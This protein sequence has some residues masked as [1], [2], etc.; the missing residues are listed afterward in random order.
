VLNSQHVLRL[1]FGEL[2]EM[3]AVRP[4]PVEASTLRVLERLNFDQLFAYSEPKR[5]LRS[6]TVRGPSL[7]IESYRDNMYYYFNFKAFPS[8][9]HRRHKGYI[10]FF[11]PDDFDTP[12]EQV[13]CEVDCDCKDY[14]FRWAWAN[15]QRDSS[16]IG[17][18]SLNQCIDQAPRITNPTA[19][20]GLCKHLL[21][22]R[23]FLYGQDS[24]FPPSDEPE[25]P[26]SGQRGKL[27]AKSQEFYRL[28]AISQQADRAI[29]DDTGRQIG[30]IDDQGEPVIT[31]LATVEP[32]PTP[33]SALA[34]L[35]NQDLELR[36]RAQIRT[37][38]GDPDAP[39]AAGELPPTAPTVPHA[40]P[41]VPEE[42]PRTNPRNPR[43]PRST[44]N[45]RTSEPPPTP[46]GESIN[47]RKDIVNG[48]DSMT[49]T[50]KLVQEVVAAN[51]VT[52]PTSPDVPPIPGETGTGTEQ[53]TP[54]QQAL[55]AL[56]SMEQLL[57]QLVQLQ[58]TPEPE[59]EAPMDQQAAPEE[60][61][62]PSVPAAPAP[63]Q[64]SRPITARKLATAV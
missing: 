52:A 12:L 60:P 31:P 49:T 45:R 18:D 11:K 5:V 54:S 32:E 8:I 36:R 10:R 28:D 21:A 56:K 42:P 39:E 41:P 47:H 38:G 63:R 35:R 29:I 23:N 26:D 3:G 62:V 58:Q 48:M 50:I 1:K 43:N 57:T 27:V 64:P 55:D 6:K 46:E 61:P 24:Q 51:Q 17:A 14:R 33:G 59:P 40:V 7:G 4:L 15:T 13:N 22:L 2:L 9:E 37:Q 25:G 20:P 53:K 34:A 30:H 19:R 44:R 16:R